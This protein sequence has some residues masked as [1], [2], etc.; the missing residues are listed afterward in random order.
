MGHLRW[1]FDLLTT[2]PLAF[3]SLDRWLVGEYLNTVFDPSL[4]LD[5]LDQAGWPGA[6]CQRDP[7]TRRRPRR[8]DRGVDG[9][10]CPITVAARQ[11]DRAP[12]PLPPV[13]PRGTRTGKTHRN[14][15]DT[16]IMSGADIVAAIALGQWCT[17]IGGPY[18]TG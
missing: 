7:N 14:R 9:T 15:V 8:G 6:C 2:E 3:A 11:L 12:V 16:G 18:L 1:W 5:G 13:A 10:C 17:L 4:T